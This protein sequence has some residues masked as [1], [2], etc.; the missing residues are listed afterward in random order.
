M[1][2]SDWHQTSGLLTLGPSLHLYGQLSGQLSLSG[3][4]TTSVGY[5]FP[6]SMHH[7]TGMITLMSVLVD[8]CIIWEA[9]LEQR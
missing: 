9:R 5:T 8:R 7:T 4:I 3:Q 1:I 2:E 6:V